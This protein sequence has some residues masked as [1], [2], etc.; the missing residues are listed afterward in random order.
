MHL[1]FTIADT[2]YRCDHSAPIDISIPLDFH[3][4]QPNAFYLPRAS[5]QAAEGGDFVGD[6]RR[7]GSCN[8]ENLI[9]SP[10]G[11]GTHTECAGH[12][13]TQRIAVVDA[14]REG[15]I[16]AVLV[17][18]PLRRADEMQVG[19]IPDSHGSDGVIAVEDL[20]DAVR[21]LGEFPHE[22]LRAFIIRTLPNSAEKRSATYSG[23]NPPYISAAAMAHLVELGVEHLLIDLPSADREDDP[24][25]TAHHIFWGMEAAG[26]P[27]PERLHCTITEMI[28]APDAVPDGLYLL[29]LQIPSFLLDAAPS[30][31]LL[32]ALLP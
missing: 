26:E 17:T 31:P 6:T 22:F 2:S 18:V 10:H 28:Y 23:G 27:A 20:A 16:P 4:E 7:G 21:G 1:T 5:A 8:C 12:I 25:L 13:S 11:N 3:G 19:D 29:N 9:I 14:L 15:F 30:R 32:Y 24:L